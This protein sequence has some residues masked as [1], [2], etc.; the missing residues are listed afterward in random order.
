MKLLLILKVLKT[1]G[2]SYV[3]I[4]E[5]FIKPFFV[6]NFETQEKTYDII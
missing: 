3:P 1:K 5:P 6:I 4:E 2:Y